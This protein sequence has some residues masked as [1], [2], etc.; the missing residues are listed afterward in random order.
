VTT[1]SP[2]SLCTES[3]AAEELEDTSLV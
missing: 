2:V 1:E 3:I